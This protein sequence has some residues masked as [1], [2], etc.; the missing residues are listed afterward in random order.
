[1][2]SGKKWRAFIL[3]LTPE[4]RRELFGKGIIDEP[5]NIAYIPNDF[6]LYDK[7]ITA[8]FNAVMKNKTYEE[9]LKINNKYREKE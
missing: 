1:M 6:A 8:V 5:D 4:Q 2:K 3:N 7:R 9:I